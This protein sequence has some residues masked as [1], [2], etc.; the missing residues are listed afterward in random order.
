[1]SIGKGVRTEATGR[2]SDENLKRKAWAAR[3]WVLIQK[4][5]WLKTFTDAESATK[6][7]ERL[8]QR[9]LKGLRLRTLKQRIQGRNA[10]TGGHR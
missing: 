6:E 9:L 4:A 10:S 5:G 2:I 7:K 3:A 8:E 1:M